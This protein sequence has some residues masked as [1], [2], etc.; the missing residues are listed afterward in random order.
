MFF[1][2]KVF[3]KADLKK[4]INGKTQYSIYLDRTRTAFA[5]ISSVSRHLVYITSLAGDIAGRKNILRW[6]IKQT[7]NG[8]I[9]THSKFAWGAQMLLDEGFKYVRCGNPEM[10]EVHLGDRTRDLMLYE[11]YT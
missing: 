4:I 11:I 7:P 3:E 5:A 1:N 6:L 8:R 9:F 10:D 2:D